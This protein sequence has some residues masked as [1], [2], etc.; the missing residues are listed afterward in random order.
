MKVCSRCKIKKSLEEFVKNKSKPDG[1]STYCKSCKRIK[2]NES[3]RTSQARRDNIRRIRETATDKLDVYLIEYLLSHPCVDCG[4]K[5]IR[6]LE[7]DHVDNNKEYN[8][9]IMRR[10]KVSVEKIGKEISKCEVRCSNCHK[11][12]HSVE[13]ND[14]RNVNTLL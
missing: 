6:V 10:N 7:F 13:K 12:R 5:D 14:W 2:D 1:Y 9:S 8:I 11:I 4:N 3:Y